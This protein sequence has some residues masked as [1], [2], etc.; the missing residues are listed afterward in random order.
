[1]YLI[2]KKKRIKAIMAFNMGI[3]TG[4]ESLSSLGRFVLI[5]VIVRSPFPKAILAKC[6]EVPGA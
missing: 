5:S 2:S 1:M 4:E 6:Y 3:R